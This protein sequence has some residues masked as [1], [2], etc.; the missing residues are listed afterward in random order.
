MRDIDQVNNEFISFPKKGR[1]IEEAMIDAK[2]NFSKLSVQSPFLKDGK[3]LGR[4]R[5]R[6]SNLLYI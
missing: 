1:T 5:N 4:N 2:P 6:Q 3:N